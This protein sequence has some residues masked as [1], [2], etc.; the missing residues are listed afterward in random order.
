M[1][2]LLAATVVVGLA[3]GLAPGAFAASTPK[4]RRVGSPPKTGCS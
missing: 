3:L 4:H 1:R 2:R